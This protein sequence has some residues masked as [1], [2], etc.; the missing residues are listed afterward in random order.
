[1]PILLFIMD[2]ADGTEHALSNPTDDSKL[3]REV[4]RADGCTAMQGDFNRLEK[5][6]LLNACG[7]VWEGWGAA[8][9]D[10]VGEGKGLSCASHSWSSQPCNSHTAGQSLGHHQSFWSLCENILEGRKH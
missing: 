9:V 6:G 5:M 1:M 4:D 3:G 7:K 8:G 10:S 2:L